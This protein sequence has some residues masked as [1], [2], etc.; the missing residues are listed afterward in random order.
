MLPGVALSEGLERDGNTALSGE[1]ELSAADGEEPVSLRIKPPTT[2]TVTQGSAMDIRGLEVYAVYADESEQAVTDYSLSG[3]DTS[4]TGAK[5]VTVTYGSLTATFPVTVE[6]A[7]QEDYI[8]GIAVIYKPQKRSYTQGE[9]LD[10]EDINNNMEVWVFHHLSPFEKVKGDKCTVT[11]YNPNQ[12]GV[13]TLT[14]SYGGK[15]AELLMKVLPGVGQSMPDNVPTLMAPRINVESVQGG[16]NVRFT[17]DS[18]DDSSFSSQYPGQRTKIYYT[19]DGSAPSSG[20][21]EYDGGDIF[22]GETTTVKAVAIL[23]NESS[24]V[25]SGRVSVPQVLA[26]KPANERHKN[27]QGPD[28]SMTQLEPGTLVSL[29]C[30]TA[31]ASVYYWFD[32]QSASAEDQRYGSSVYIDRAYADANDVVTLNAYAVKDG[33]K[34]SN[35]MKLRYQ[36]P[37]EEPPREEQVNISVGTARS[38]AGEAV[39]A[40][41]SITT[42]ESSCVTGFTITVR[43]DRRTFRFESVS[44]AETGGAQSEAV[45]PAGDLFAAPDA[46]AGLVR[47]MYSGNPV[48]GGEMCMLNFRVY[49]SAENAPYELTVDG[50][51]AR[52]STSTGRPV[53][54]KTYNGTISLEGS[55]N[56]QLTAAVLFSGEDNRDASAVSELSESSNVTASISIDRESVQDYTSSLP[57]DGVGNPPLTVVASVFVAFYDENGDMLALETWEIDLSDLARLLFDRMLDMP[58]ETCDIKTM[59]LSESL[60]PIM[61]AE[62][63]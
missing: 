38:R 63:L 55:H 20:S 56:S 39:S 2:Q 46:A 28:G 29:L 24:T 60:T 35:V 22:L 17:R 15:S 52:V 6:A 41:L 47:I 34:N 8:T 27:N 54:E 50:E 58:G 32:G 30:D 48:A 26:P 1:A 19:L 10:M 57:R 62:E 43:Y 33:C 36:L 49:D 37:H 13:Q 9:Q 12:L 53:S 23:G 21:M 31:G 3:L 18:N 4:Q 51:S 44:P 25:S 45:I 61:A 16:K 11:G 42:E 7:P 40:S 59:I 14:V 5:A